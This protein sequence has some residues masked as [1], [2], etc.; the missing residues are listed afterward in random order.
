MSSRDDFGW[1]A[2]PRDRSNLPSKE[3]AKAN[4]VQIDFD[5]IWP[6]TVLVAQAQ[7]YAKQ[8]L[9]EQTYS[10]SLRVYYLGG[11]TILK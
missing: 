6:K 4:A 5:A 7:N 2:V 9:P 10:H 3:Q 8:H 11:I 1:S